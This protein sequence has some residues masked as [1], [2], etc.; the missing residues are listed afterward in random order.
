MTDGDRDRG[1]GLIEI[2]GLGPGARPMPRRADDQGPVVEPDRGAEG[3][4]RSGRGLLHG[5]DRLAEG[6]ARRIG[7]EEVGGPGVARAQVGP[8]CADQCRV[9]RAGDR[10]AE[11]AAAA[12]GLNERRE[13]V[14]P[15]VIEQERRTCTGPAVLSSGDPIRMFGPTDA[16]AEP[17]PVDVA[18]RGLAIDV[19]STPVVPSNR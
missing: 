5:G 11:V 19:I 17:N 2:D 1:T 6:R 4:T 12:V 9:L 8:G 18:G 15:D 10:G 16:T 3:V 7:V 13:Q 14:R